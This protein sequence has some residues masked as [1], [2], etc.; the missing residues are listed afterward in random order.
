MIILNYCNRCKTEFQTRDC[1]YCRGNATHSISIINLCP[2]DVVVIQDNG[3]IIFPKTNIHARLEAKTERDGFSIFSKTTFGK[4]K[5]LPKP[6]VGTYY[7]VSQLIKS[8]LPERED[9]CVPAEVV[10][11]MKGNIIGCKSLG[12]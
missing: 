11:D 5:N 7:I 4:V 6:A 10:R 2:H 9:L 12:F 1:P 3:E 8:A